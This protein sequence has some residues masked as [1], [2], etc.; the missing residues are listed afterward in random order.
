MIKVQ[1]QVTG[2][3]NNGLFNR[4]TEEKIHQ[5]HTSHHMQKL[6]LI[7]L[8]GF[9]GCSVVNNPPAL[10]ETW[11]QSLGREDPP[12]KKMASHSSVLAWEIPWTEEPG[13]LQSMGSQKSQTRLRDKATIIEEN[14]TWAQERFFN[15]KSIFRYNKRLINSNHMK[16]KRLWLAKKFFQ[17][18]I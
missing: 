16:I 5:N 3:F 11:V 4:T 8:A 9:P 2:A 10:Q 7:K 1:S 13:R 18:L 12:E 6:A 14:I 15:H 17:K